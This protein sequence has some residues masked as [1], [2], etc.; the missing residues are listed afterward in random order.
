MTAGTVAERRGNRGEKRLEVASCKFRRLWQWSELSLSSCNHDK[1][2][3]SEPRARCGRKNIEIH[4]KRKIT[5]SSCSFPPAPQSSL[6]RLKSTSGTLEKRE[7]VDFVINEE[8]MD[9][10]SILSTDRK[11][12]R[13]ERKKE[14]GGEREETY[15]RD[16][17]KNWLTSDNSIEKRER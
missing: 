5:H 4:V 3:E 2:V 12:Q 15:N 14:D 13:K 1:H 16:C 9:L 7:R 6:L 8:K 10:S 11:K 17:I